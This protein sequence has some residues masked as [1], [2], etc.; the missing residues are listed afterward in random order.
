MLISRR[1]CI[2]LMEDAL[3][4]PAW[5]NC[6][7]VGRSGLRTHG[8]S[9]VSAARK[10]PASPDPVTAYVYCRRSFDQGV[11]IFTYKWT[12]RA[13]PIT[14]SQT[15][16]SRLRGSLSGGFLRIASRQSGDRS[17]LLNGLLGISGRHQMKSLA[18]LSLTTLPDNV[19]TRRPV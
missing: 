11:Q 13:G 19:K 5:M 10:G 14:Q 6:G 18:V 1:T 16:K 9:T 12:T 3:R 17:M 2:K 8:Q 15:K 4:E 7:L